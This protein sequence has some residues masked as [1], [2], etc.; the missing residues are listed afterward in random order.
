MSGDKYSTLAV[1]ATQ[2]AWAFAMICI[3]FAE[4]GKAHCDIGSEM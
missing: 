2:P 4:F 3:V 1:A